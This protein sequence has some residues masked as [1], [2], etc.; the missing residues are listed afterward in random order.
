MII[1]TSRHQHYCTECDTHGA[2]VM[3]KNGCPHCA[4][5][6]QLAS[7][8][9][10]RVHV[11]EWLDTPSWKDDPEDNEN[12]ARFFLDFRRMPAWKLSAYAPFMEQFK[13]FCTYKEQRYR[14][15]GA[16]RMGDVWL[17]NDHNQSHGYDLRVDVTECTMW[18]AT[19]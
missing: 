15:T 2:P 5:L 3:F 17:A 13:L 14:C 6:K 12:Y 11:D 1:T 4:A 16:S 8:H 18:K 7:I 9:S 10:D 19:P